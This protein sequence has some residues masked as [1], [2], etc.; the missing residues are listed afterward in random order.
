MNSK[1][2]T[3]GIAAVVLAYAS[4][5]GAQE[6]IDR[7]VAAPARAAEIGIGL[8]YAQP[9]GDLTLRTGDRASNFARAGGQIDGE[10]GYRIDPRWLIGV[11]GG[12]GQFHAPGGTAQDIVATV[13]AGVQAQVHVNPH[14]RVDPWVGFGAGWRGFFINPENSATRALHGLQIA[15]VRFGVDYRVSDGVALG[16]AVGMD[17]TMFTTEVRSGE[18]P[19]FESLGRERYTLTPF[20]FGGIVGRFDIGGR[21]DSGER[22]MA[23]AF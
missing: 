15:R 14:R 13:N 12:Y 11:Y 2:V 16:P 22:M 18:G 7:T 5:T 6:T 21:R 4:T 9:T 1:L 8:G 17:A 19:T 20:F 10:I 23:K 3:S